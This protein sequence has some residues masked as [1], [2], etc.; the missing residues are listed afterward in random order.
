[1]FLA[2]IISEYNPFHYGHAALIKK[3]RQNG[4]THIVAVMSGNFVQRGEPAVLSKW[5][6][7]RQA[8]ENGVDLVV[9][10]PLPWALSGAEKFALGGVS[11]LDAMGAD[12]I[13]FGS[14]TGDIKSLKKAADILQSRSF[15]EAIKK[16]LKNGNT[17]AKARQNAVLSLFDSKTAELLSSP[18]NI[19]GI[20]YIKSID[21]LKSKIEPFTTKRVGAA[22]DTANYEGKYAAAS[23]I[24]SLMLTGKEYSNFMPNSAYSTAQK[25]I[26]EGAAPACIKFAERAILAK[27]RCMS[28]SDFE[29]LPDIS[30][31]LENRIYSAVRKAESLEGLYFLI[32]SKRYT[33]ARIRRIVLSAFLGIKSSHT[34]GLPP[35]IHVLGFNER[36]TE[37]LHSI[38]PKVKIPIITNSSDIFSLDKIGKNMVELESR[39]TD[40]FTLCTPKI[41]PC[42]LYMTK[43]IIFLPSR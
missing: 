9:E 30:E 40:L 21:K 3:V 4:A 14:E 31:G 35:Y 34:I 24:R 39:A 18:N 22:H 1:M 13:S 17:F 43:G 33:L 11:L 6:R 25:E 27:L 28:R 16:E 32:K 23:Q 8:L 41:S 2:G 36:G 26:N 38:K 20:E 5:A 7:T 19:L 15:S 37:I 10:L 12:I 42:G 29:M